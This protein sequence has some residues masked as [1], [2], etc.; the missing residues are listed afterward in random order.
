MTP[1]CVGNGK[2]WNKNYARRRNHAVND[3]EE[4][5]GNEKQTRG[6]KR[7][8]K[9]HDAPRFDFKGFISWCCICY[10]QVNMTALELSSAWCIRKW[11]EK[12]EVQ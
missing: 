8:K 9:K 7:S 2:R 11:R 6:S 3:G 12:A 10:D 1:G 4:A 5:D